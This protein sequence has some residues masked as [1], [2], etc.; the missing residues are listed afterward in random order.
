MPTIRLPFLS[1]LALLS[2][3]GLSAVAFSQ[4]SPI[5]PV[6]HFEPYAVSGATP[7]VDGDV[8]GDGVPDTIYVTLPVAGQT[9][10]TLTAELRSKSGGAPTITA[11]IQ[12]ACTVNSVMLA[13]LN[14]DGKLDAVAT[15]N[16]G[17]VAVMPGNGDGT[18]QSAATYQVASAAKAVAADLNGDGFPDLVVAM[19][20]GY[21]GS[22]FGILLNQGGTGAIQFGTATLYA[23]IN[24]NVQIFGSAQL[25]VGD[26]NGD[27]RVDVVTGGIPD[28]TS[29]EGGIFLGNG[30][31][32]LKYASEISGTFAMG[33]F[34]GDGAVD[35]AAS[36]GPPTSILY[37]SGVWVE[38]LQSSGS[39]KS[40]GYL[41]MLIGAASLRAVD[42]NG[43]GHLDV[44]MMTTSTTTVL[45][46]DGKG[47]LTVGRSY[48]TP[49][50]YYGA[51][52]G[53]D[54]KV[55]LIFTTP[56]GFYTL[57]GNGDGTFQGMPALFASDVATTGDTNGDGVTDV[58]SI[59]QR[60]GMPYAVAGRGDGA[61]T[62]LQVVASGLI[63]FP[64]V[65][66]FDGDGQLDIVDVYSNNSNN[67]PQNG[68]SRLSW[69]KGN[70][71]GYF[72]GSNLS[73]SLGVKGAMSAVAGDFNSD[74]KTDVVVAYT[75]T[76]S[77]T[78]SGLL[79]ARGNGDG[80]F[81]APSSPLATSNTTVSGRVL[82]A[83]LNGDGKPD[84][85]WGTTVYLNQGGGTFSTIALPLQTTVLAIGDLDGDG[86]A[87]VVLQD[88]TVHSGVGDGTFRTTALYTISTPSGSTNVSASIGDLNGDGHA[89]VVMQYLAD[90]AGLSVAFGDGSGGFVADS[91]VYA[92]AGKTP[93][94]GV[95][96]RLNSQA[97][98]LSHDNRMDYV[99][100]AD[101]AAVSLLNQT[102]PAPGAEARLASSV[103]VKASPTSV[104]PLA[105]FSLVSYVTGLNPTGVVSFVSNDGTVLG[106]GTLTDVGFMLGGTSQEGDAQLYP[107]S[108]AFP[109][110][111]TV[112]ASFPGDTT[113]APSVSAPLT[114]TVAKG[115]SATA[116]SVSQPF[117]PTVSG[118][119]Y[120]GRPAG[121]NAYV[122][123][124]NP[125]AQVTYTSGAATL[126]SA[127]V[128]GGTT[129]GNA[130]FKYTFPSAGS[131]QITASYPEDASNLPSSSTVTVSVVDGPDF[132][133]SATP[134]ANT[135]KAGGTAT[136]TITLTPLRG[137]T[138]NVTLACDCGGST[139]TLSIYAGQS[140]S[141]PLTLQTTTTPSGPR[142]VSFGAQA[143]LL[144]LVGFNRRLRR[145]SRR[146]QLGVL[147]AFLAVGLGG[148]SACSSGNSQ[149]TNNTAP[150]T[151]TGT[152]YNI[153]ISGTDQVIQVTHT[154][155]LQLTITQ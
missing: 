2:L 26:V 108:F 31:G 131:Y 75:D 54:G 153:V 55:S 129:G 69:L 34:N 57:Q 90:M 68:I 91:N 102:N 44:V 3:S 123:G 138:G 7:M 36:S 37:S 4:T 109:G 154:V 17:V 118:D 105:P 112:T 125:T 149:S 86:V 122:T 84:L 56:R 98:A 76:S 6:L 23:G 128:Q 63:G 151:P 81:T 74:G 126:G 136:Y 99:A 12:V 9:G 92:F 78:T 33:D 58:V 40:Y 25:S 5:F 14:K 95:L 114:I 66:D 88:G 72:Q 59:Q 116:L 119:Y 13:D 150:T 20:T 155:K 96:A 130:S 152:T 32:T 103:S 107:V 87:D 51:R 11:G 73:Y 113:N 100:F 139:T 67:F 19:A 64:V 43:D 35:F 50:D 80:T 147:V 141:V 1:C 115:A 28:S 134:T 97:P 41:N 61:F 71:I 110:T 133:L 120:T 145:M 127:S 21:K 24:G 111:Y 121:L 70:G 62:L 27:G 85:I 39:F 45:L 65:A 117:A 10:S 46:G 101:G 106:K 124:F 52:T 89:D 140:A 77:G 18:F 22:V 79:M 8:N 48:A 144:V 29:T 148:L 30:D 60:F 53:D 82:Q 38:S 104:V 93:V 142:A 132:S 49:G 146:L 137:Y 135:V 94:S 15:C 16:E 83:D 47:N 143:A 42:V